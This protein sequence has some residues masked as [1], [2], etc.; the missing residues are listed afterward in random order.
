VA[1][2]EEESRVKLTAE[3]AI[4]WERVAAVPQAPGSDRRVREGGETWLETSLGSY[5]VGE[6]LGRAIL[7]RGKRASKSVL[8]ELA[9]NGWGVLQAGYRAGQSAHDS[10]GT[11][12]A[13]VPALQICTA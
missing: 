4:G 3:G 9:G 2:P 11:R 1:A 6:P 12:A 10:C 7:K 5:S 8:R 13:S